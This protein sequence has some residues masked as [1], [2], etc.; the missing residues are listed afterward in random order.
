MSRREI[1]RRLQ[2]P[3]PRR[4]LRRRLQPDPVKP[5]V[6]ERRVW[7]ASTCTGRCCRAGARPPRS[8]RHHQQGPPDRRPDHA[9]ERGGWTKAY[10]PVELMDIHADDTAASLG[11]RM[12]HVGAALCSAPRAG[13]PSSAAATTETAGGRADLHEDLL[14]PS[15]YRLDPPGRRGGR[16]HPRPVALLAPGSEVEAGSDPSASRP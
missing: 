3:G 9:D 6:L 16:P 13:P 10:H 7:A 2:E 12:T 4:G 11:D 5:E 1:H 14:R 8:A 15:A